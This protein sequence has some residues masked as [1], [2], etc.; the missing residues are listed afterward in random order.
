MISSLFSEAFF[1]QLFA[2]ARTRCSTLT[3]LQCEQSL[4]FEIQ[5]ESTAIL[6]YRRKRF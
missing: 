2:K 1:H 6:A 5:V 4:L 3:I